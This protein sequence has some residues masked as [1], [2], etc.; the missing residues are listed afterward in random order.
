[1]M[2]DKTVAECEAALEAGYRAI[3]EAR[4]QNVPASEMLIYHERLAERRADL[5]K[6]R[7]NTGK[8]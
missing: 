8:W 3:E 7:R 4:R 2:T 6:A 1:M 5:E